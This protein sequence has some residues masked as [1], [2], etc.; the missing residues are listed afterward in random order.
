MQVL[1]F[2]KPF[3][4]L[5]CSGAMDLLS[6]QVEVQRP[7]DIHSVRS[8]EEPKGR[9]DTRIDVED[10]IKSVARIVPVSDVEDAPIAYGFHES[11]RLLPDR[12][13]SLAESKRSHSRVHGILS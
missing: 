7:D 13:I 6:G 3:A 12:L 4:S 9:P 5:G 11:P 10:L 2:D 8:C 1:I